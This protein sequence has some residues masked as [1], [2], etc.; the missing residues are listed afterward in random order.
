M[1]IYLFIYLSIQQVERTSVALLRA[2]RR[3]A[4]CTTGFTRPTGRCPVQPSTPL[5]PHQVNVIYLFIAS[6]APRHHQMV[7]SSCE[8]PEHKSLFPSCP[9]TSRS[10]RQ[11]QPTASIPWLDMCN[12][13]SIL[14]VWQSLWVVL[15]E[16]HCVWSH[17][18]L[19]NRVSCI[20]PSL[21]NQTERV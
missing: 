10:Y 11:P 12:S 9:P 4:V 2:T 1:F 7:P 15:S 16:L 6:T 3:F 18:Q 20:I 5:G 17:G 19:S 21:C 13:A 14:R 8:D